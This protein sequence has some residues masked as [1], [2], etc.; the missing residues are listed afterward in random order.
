MTHAHIQAHTRTLT[1]TRTHAKGHTWAHGRAKPEMT[2][3]VG[4]VTQT[5]DSEQ[6]PARPLHAP[7]HALRPI[8]RCRTNGSPAAP[9]ARNCDPDRAYLRLRRSLPMVRVPWPEP[10]PASQCARSGPPPSAT[11]AAAPPRPANLKPERRQ[12]ARRVGVWMR[13][14]RNDGGGGGGTPRIR[15]Q[16]WGKRESPR[17]VAAVG[18]RTRRTMASE[19]RS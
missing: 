11:A 10:E 12:P 1:R 8:I 2:R 4:L 17:A 5:G 13:G 16:R 6:P 18:V 15:V 19:S 7:P 3:T 9:P 14:D